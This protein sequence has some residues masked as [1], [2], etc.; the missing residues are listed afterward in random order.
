MTMRVASS[1]H[2]GQMRSNGSTGWTYPSAYTTFSPVKLPSALHEPQ[3]GQAIP[4]IWA[5]LV[6][7]NG[8]ALQLSHQPHTWETDPCPWWQAEVHGIVLAELDVADVAEDHMQSG[9]HLVLRVR[10]L[11][12]PEVVKFSWAGTAHMA[13][14]HLPD[15]KGLVTERA[16][17]LVHDFVSVQVSP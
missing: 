8:R 10:M 13:R 2:F 3:E 1:P 17:C 4:A 14:G 7:L 12:L 11:A 16:V 9:E 5:I 6:P 15:L